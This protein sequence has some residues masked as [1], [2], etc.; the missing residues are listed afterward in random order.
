MEGCKAVDSEAGKMRRKGGRRQAV[1]QLL[2]LQSLLE[3][4]VHS[5]GW[6][7]D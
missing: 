1:Q 6:A 5:A 2:C 3:R 7:M 4:H